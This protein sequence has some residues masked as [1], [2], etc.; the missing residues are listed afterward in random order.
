[1]DLRLSTLMSHLPDSIVRLVAKPVVPGIVVDDL[2]QCNL[3][4]RDNLGV[5]FHHGSLGEE[6]LA[7]RERA[8]AQLIEVRYVDGDQR[9]TVKVT[10]RQAHTMQQDFRKQVAQDQIVNELKL[11]ARPD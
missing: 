2:T 4:A 6:L 9:G 5:V 11:P 10:E 7:N 8:E 3:P 1:M